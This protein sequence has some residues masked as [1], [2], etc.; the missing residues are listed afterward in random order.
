MHRLMHWIRCAFLR[1]SWRRRAPAGDF[2]VIADSDG[3]LYIQP[4]A[5]APRDLG[6]IYFGSAAA[7]Y[8]LPGIEAD[9]IKRLAAISGAPVMG[10]DMD[11]WMAAR[12]AENLPRARGP[13]G[14]PDAGSRS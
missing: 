13:I 9:P 6:L 2:L 10:E 5:R 3:L 1:I 12:T 7:H 14:A 4:R 8:P 11:A